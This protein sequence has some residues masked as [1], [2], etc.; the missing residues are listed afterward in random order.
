MKQIRSLADKKVF[1]RLLFLIFILGSILFFGIRYR[2]WYHFMEQYTLFQYTGGYFLNLLNQPGGFNEYVTEF[3]TQAFVWSYGGPVVIT[4]LLGMISGLF[5]C[6]LRKCVGEVSMI[7]ALL[8]AFLFWLYPVESI[9]SILAI[10]SAFLATT[11]Y[12]SLRNHTI[13]YIVGFLLITLLYF[14]A[15]PA[16]LLAAAL[17]AVYELCTGKGNR[18]YIVFIAAI[19]WSLLLP[20]LAL[21]MIYVVPMRE[22][23][24]S[25]HLFHPEYTVPGSFWLEWISFPVLALLAYL[26]RGRPFM[27]HAPW[28][29]VVYPVGLLFLVGGSI[30]LTKNPIEQAYRYDYYARQD[31]WEKIITHAQENGIKD[32]NTLVYLNLAASKTGRFN[33]LL[34]QFPQIGE[35]GFIPHDPKSRLGLIQASEVAWQLNLINSAQRFAFVGVL[36]AERC[37]QPRLMKRLVETYLVNEE[38]KA[39][40]KYIKILESTCIYRDWARRQRALLDPEVC[41]STVWVAEKRAL[42]MITDTPFDPTKAFA[43]TLAYMLDDH[44]DNQSAFEYAMGYVLLKKDF[45]ILMH[46]M[47]LLRDHKRPIAPL[48]QEAICLY[49][50]AVKN[51]PESFRSFR[52]DP[53]V[54]ERFSQFLQAA[55]TMSPVLLKQQYSNTFYYYA[56]FVPTPKQTER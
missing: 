40:E 39:A 20:L 5:Y 8:P 9:A 3:L 44:L 53:A 18:K 54:Y 50:A 48:Y 37:V 23:Y 47:E 28:K 16:H 2:Y 10:G 45:S 34:F 43:G 1:D 21:R 49:Y 55:K 51:D 13:R 26:L 24:L 12:I 32:K 36:S 30:Y 7:V 27:R 42:N 6:F 25:K 33:E 19:A 4:A 31:Q 46:Y 22:A 11:V 15:T 41:V 56:Q 14:L 29:N 38:Y 52:I 17:M 35:D